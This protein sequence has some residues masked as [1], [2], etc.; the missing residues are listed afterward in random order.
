M[1]THEEKIRAV[2]LYE[3]SG[4]KA[5][6]VVKTLGYPAPNILKRWHREYIAT[7]SIHSGKLSKYTDEQKQNAIDYYRENGRSIARTIKE[8]GYPPYSTMSDWLKEAGSEHHRDC[9]DGSAVVKYS[10]EHKIPI[11]ADYM[12]SGDP[13]YKVAARHDVS[14]TSLHKWKDQL[15]GE[16][17]VV[18]VQR[19]QIRVIP[20]N[21]EELQVQ[22]LKMQEDFEQLKRQFFL[23]QMEYDVLEKAAEIIKKDRGI[24]LREITNSEKADV[25]DALRCKYRLNLLLSIMA[26]SKSSYFYQR[27]V[28]CLPDKYTD[29]RSLVKWEFQKSNQ[30]YGYRR[31]HSLLQKNGT[32]V[33][34]KIVRRVMRE[35]HLVVI[36]I[37]SRKYNSYR[38]EITPAVRNLIKR[39]FHADTPNVKWLTDISEFAL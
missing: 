19:K 29:V 37:R 14:P 13:A 23:K 2:E 27:A 12:M 33:S 10:H 20:D 39:D 5:G 32:L 7:G 34:E 15:L 22:M 17:I 38:G 24:N 1:Y 30:C 28:K 11:V 3:K 6:I 4:R 31:L 8:L 18:E 16:G 9:V 36:A 26:M 21:T 35:D 25:I